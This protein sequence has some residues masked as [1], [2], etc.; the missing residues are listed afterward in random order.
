[1]NATKKDTL[2]FVRAKLSTD[3]VWAT[4]AL[5]RI[6]QENQTNDEQVNQTTSHDN[7]I[8][9]TE[10]PHRRGLSNVARRADAHSGLFTIEPLDGGGTRATWSVFIPTTPNPTSGFFL[11]LPRQHVIEL[12][13][14]VDDALKYIISMGVVV[15]GGPE[16]PA[17]KAH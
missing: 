12:D 2:S 6:Y 8:G 7:G 15:P 11:M 16:N 10:P 1:M 17:L 3:P 5:V 14:S 13:M 4:K 9:F